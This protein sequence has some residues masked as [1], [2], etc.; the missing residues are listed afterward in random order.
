[1]DASSTAVKCA[2]LGSPIQH[3]LSPTLHG[4]AYA[5]LG[6]DDWSYGAV[7]VEE[8]GLADFLDHLGVGWRGLS[9]T[10]P[11]KRAA[12]PLVDTLDPW[13]RQA[14]AVNT[15]VLT[16]GSRHGH[17]TDIPGA[18]AAIRERTDVPLERAVVLG[19]GATA[20]SMLLALGELGCTTATLLVR[21]PSR[22][23]QTLDVVRAADAA[24]A[25]EVGTLDADPGPADIVISTIPADAQAE[26]LVR[27]LA[28]V[29]VVFDVIYDPWP[30]PLAASVGDDRVLVSGLDL[31]VHQ[32][33]LQVRLMT[34]IDDVPLAVLREA[35]QTA[36]SRRK[37]EV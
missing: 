18:V 28:D 13:A 33:L 15:I 20:A 2:V 19:G 16:D 8:D 25:V 31:L 6:L 24:P 37:E 9:L 34:G 5:A 27:R 14:G 21:E 23:T 17:N 29:P 36:L 22:A 32:A 35:G 26:E 11:L 30:T 7:T 1:V 3:S 4:A 10:M 12:V